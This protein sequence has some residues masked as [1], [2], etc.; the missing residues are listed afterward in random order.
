MSFFP[1]DDNK[2]NIS[3]DDDKEN[4]APIRRKTVALS[5]VVSPVKKRLKQTASDIK[6]IL[7]ATAVP[8]QQRCQDDALLYWSKEF[9]K[10]GEDESV[11][12]AFQCIQQSETIHPLLRGFVNNDDEWEYFIDILKMIHQADGKYKFLPVYVGKCPV[13]DADGGYNLSC[14]GG[15]CKGCN[16]D[17]FRNCASVDM[18]LTLHN[19]I[20]SMTDGVFS[21]EG[22]LVPAV[23]VN[24]RP[25]C[26][27]PPRP[28]K[29]VSKKQQYYCEDVAG[30]YYQDDGT[31][32][33]GS[34]LPVHYC[35]EITSPEAVIVAKGLNLFG[36]LAHE[37]DCKPMFINVAGTSGKMVMSKLDNAL[38][39]VHNE[40]FHMS[41]ISTRR[42][43]YGTGEEQTT[44]VTQL[45]DGLEKRVESLFEE[46][47]PLKLKGAIEKA[48]VDVRF[49]YYGSDAIIKERV[50]ALEEKQEAELAIKEEKRQKREERKAEL[51]IKEEKRQQRKR[52]QEEKQEEK[53]KAELAIKEEKRQQ[54]KLAQEEKW[55]AEQ[56]KWKAECAIK[57]ARL[58]RMRALEEKCV[59]E[60]L[61][62]IATGDRNT[63]AIEISS[64]SAGDD[65]PSGW[66]VKRYRKTGGECV[67]KIVRFWFSPGRNKRFT[68]KK[69]A[70]TFIDIL[71][72]PSI[73]GD[74][75]KAAKVYKARG[76]RF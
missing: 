15:R 47:A 68:L 58:K 18:L 14:G 63:P 33:Q 52:A 51:A 75:D 64:G 28:S 56:E 13:R 36:K 45:L 53:R 12:E 37:L 66:I 16:V 19:A 57:E 67:G 50:R 39:F 54:R 71:K 9:D 35:P 31:P 72:E 22:M 59:E 32:Y 73:D 3:N 30:L 11:V 25:H 70:M 49:K 20:S 17:A 7:Q 43:S 29:S 48:F 46:S 60:Y 21:A 44:K 62:R 65:F 34:K 27:L 6:L 69:H 23:V 42:T 76:H 2:E 1:N 61:K 24:G 74:E 41:N 5:A 4:I 38:F 40:M 26:P 8:V 55:K 10:L